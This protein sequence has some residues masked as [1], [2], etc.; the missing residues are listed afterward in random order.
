MISNTKTTKSPLVTPAKSRK[1]SATPNKSSTTKTAPEPKNSNS[2][3]FSATYGSGN[4]NSN[5]SEDNKTPKP[6]TAWVLR[7]DLCLKCTGY[8][9]VGCD[10]DGNC[11]CTHAKRNHSVS[12]KNPYL[13]LSPF[14]TCPSVLQHFKHSKKDPAE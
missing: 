14:L 13:S 4:G 6:A 9:S 12:L 3:K 1:P 7:C 2:S 5:G 11:Y 10:L 8:E